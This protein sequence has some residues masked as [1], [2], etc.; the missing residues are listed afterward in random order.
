MAGAA[1]GGLGRVAGA[2]REAAGRRAFKARTHGHQLRQAS[3][4]RCAG[5]AWVWQECSF[6]VLAA[7]GGVCSNGGAAVL[8]RSD[9]GVGVRVQECVLARMAC[10]R[11][12]VLCGA[13][14]APGQGSSGGARVKGWG[15][16][17]EEKRFFK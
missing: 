4:Q 15:H 13:A 8:A 7:L 2:G 9:V 11:R 1:D 16:G 6:L 3:L 5:A 12:I 10:A 17:T 14:C